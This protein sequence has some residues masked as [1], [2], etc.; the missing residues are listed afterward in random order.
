MPLQAPVS[1]GSFL[2]GEDIQDKEKTL[3]VN[4]APERIKANEGFGDD[5]GMTTRYYFKDGET[6][7]S[8]D[9][10]SNRLANEWNR[11]ELELGDT[12]TLKRTGKAMNTKY[13]IKKLKNADGSEAEDGV[14]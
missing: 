10:N 11:A 9:T 8:L 1:G 4:G 7:I 14:F 5:D 6:E 12:I 2:R 3:V 13:E